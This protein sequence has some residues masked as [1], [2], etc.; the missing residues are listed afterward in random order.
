MGPRTKTISG[1]T[2]HPKPPSTDY[3]SVPLP[4]DVGSTQG[5]RRPAARVT[6]HGSI[7]SL[8]NPFH[9]DIEE[10]DPELLNDEPEVIILLRI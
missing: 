9:A 7:S 8:Q 1:L 2:P 3:L 5:G 6:E 4:S 10:D